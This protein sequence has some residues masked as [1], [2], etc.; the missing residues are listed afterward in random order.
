[1]ILMTSTD[2]KS[3]LVRLTKYHKSLENHLN[4]LTAN[5]IQLENRWRFFKAASEGD[6]AE[7]FRSGWE[8]TEE[9]FRDYINQAQKIKA[10]L[11]ERIDSLSEFNKA[12]VGL[13]T[14]NRGSQGSS[15]D[16]NNSSVLLPVNKDGSWDKNYCGFFN[17]AC[18]EEVPPSLKGLYYIHNADL[19]KQYIGKSDD[20]IKGRL[21]AH[22]RGS[23]NKNLK[24]L[25]ASG[26]ELSFYCWESP[27]PKYEEAIEIKRFKEV[28]LL[29]GQR[30]EN[31]PLIEYLD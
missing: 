31:K 25:V 24:A 29:K 15:F 16:I 6:Y 30:R 2:A 14:Y 17:Q 12:E 21:K 26:E 19:S 5:F 1:M 9:R 28:G 7:Q 27:D 23:H 20:C 4:H 11:I 8:K 10:L 13:E 3:L 22:L 18:V